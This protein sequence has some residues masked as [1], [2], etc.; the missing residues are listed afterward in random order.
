MTDL[1]CVWCVKMNKMKLTLDCKP[2]TISKVIHN[3]LYMALQ[4][5]NEWCTN[6]GVA[7]LR[8]QGGHR[9]LGNGVQGQGPRGSRGKAPRSQIYTVRS[10]QMLFST[11][12]LPSPSSSALPQKLFRSAW[13]A[14]PNTA[15]ATW[16]RAHPWWLCYCVQ[17][18]SISVQLHAAAATTETT[19]D[20]SIQKKFIVWMQPLYYCF[21]SVIK[22]C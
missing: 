1:Q 5:N 4:T 13:I 11:G 7:R 16:A 10:C 8:S 20:F 19:F 21:T 18:L 2:S 15:G 14:W 3:V 9:G 17:T 6:S 22:I 12:L